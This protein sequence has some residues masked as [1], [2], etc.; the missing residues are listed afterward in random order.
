MSKIEQVAAH[1]REE[2]IR[3]RWTKEIPGREE[4]ATELGV[5]SKTVESA[6]RLLEA[7]GVLI[8]QGAGRRRK[9][10]NLNS[11]APPA[12]RI[13]LM[14]YEESDREN[15]YFLKAL[16]QLSALGHV[17]SFSDKSLNDLGMSVE[18]VANYVRQNPVDAWVIIGGSREI[19]TWFSEQEI[20]VYAL[21]G[22]SGELPIASVGVNK[23]PA[24]TEAVRKL[25]SLDHRRIVMLT[26]TERRKPN[27]GMFEQA[28]LDEL[29]QHGIKIGTYHLP[30]W[31]DNIAGFHRCLESLFTTTP[32]TALFI[33][34]ATRLIAAQ[35]H[36]ARKGI[37][38]PENISLICHDPSE[39]FSWC[40]PEISH[41]N[42]DTNLV[43]N[44]ILRWSN[45]IARGKD[46]RKQHW[47]LAEF[48]G[49]GT[50]GPAPK[51]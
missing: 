51:S 6:L 34:E 30:D 25:V 41:I 16:H 22:R 27:P 24:M 12:L 29:V 23:I 43:F 37:I 13:K 26:R 5:N 8:S 20:P 4:L 33:S 10:A 15:I 40:D 21:F 48:V 44:S 47:L 28:F 50:I 18:R 19:L 46:Y 3:G 9:I 49:G 36:L 14:L 45:S 32:P 7:K 38:A 11:S 31:E 39:A 17:T 35:Q 42:W 2:L 1:L